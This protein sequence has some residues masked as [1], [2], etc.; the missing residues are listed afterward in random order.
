MD[1]RLLKVVH[2][3]AAHMSKARQEAAG[4]RGRPRGRRQPRAPRLPGKWARR[5]SRRPRPTGRPSRPSRG[6]RRVRLRAAGRPAARLEEGRARR[7]QAAAR[8]GPHVRCYV[9]YPGGPGAAGADG[10]GRRRSRRQPPCTE[11]GRLARA[12][13]PPAEAVVPSDP[14]P[15]WATSHGHH[16]AASAVHH[17]RIR[18]HGASGGQV[19]AVQL[20]EACAGRV[21]PRVPPEAAGCP[22]PP[23]A[24]GCLV[25]AGRRMNFAS[26]KVL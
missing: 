16:C 7:R 24:A 1:L 2:D 15:L 12:P 26:K 19:P 9:V 8:R 25:G 10:V 21:P 4:L 18:A 17:V 23:A 13:E 11:G 20:P 22:R 3:T 6:A 5:S 14:A